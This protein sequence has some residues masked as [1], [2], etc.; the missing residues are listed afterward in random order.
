MSLHDRFRYTEEVPLASHFYTFHLYAHQAWSAIYRACAQAQHSI[1]FEHYILRDDAIGRPFIELFKRKSREGVKIRLLLDA[2]GSAEYLQAGLQD[3]L[4]RDGIDLL[5][6][7]SLLPGTLSHHT[8]WFFRDH[9]KIVLVD[10]ETGFTGGVCFQEHMRDWRDTVLELRGP[11]TAQ[12]ETAFDDMW[13]RAQKRKPPRRP[14]PAITKEAPF[15]FLTHAPLRGQRHLYYEFLRRIESARSYIQ[16][17]TP[18]LIPTRTFRNALRKALRRGVQLQILV[19]AASDNV[20]AGIATRSY[21]ADFLGRDAQIF[22]YPAPMNHTKT[23]VIDGSWGTI[24][25]LNIDRLSL[26]FNFEANMVSVDTA[27]ARE[28]SDHFAE[29]CTRATSISPA[30]WR[31]RSLKARVLE[32]GVRPFRFVL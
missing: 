14:V 26:N 4:L 30:Q 32:Y 2:I 23:A 10:T 27:F 21:Y 15:A 19:P 24:G 1:L 20:L 8:P 17:T 28:L 6:F 22:E 12:M 16:L 9:R 29:D 31:S 11:V 3:E 25:S 5:F 18:Y 13:A 7:N